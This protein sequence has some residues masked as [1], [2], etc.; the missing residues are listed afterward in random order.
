MDLEI[1]DNYIKRNENNSMIVNLIIPNGVIGIKDSAFF[2][3]YSLR[4][5]SMPES[6][7]FIE[8][9]AFNYCFKITDSTITN[10]VI[11]SEIV[12]KKSIQNPA[13]DWAVDALRMPLLQ[14]EARR[15]VNS[16]VKDSKYNISNNID[17]LRKIYEEAVFFNKDDVGKKECLK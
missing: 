1:K 7:K 16:F 9:D 8:S 11:L 14:P 13:D 3:C 5:V 17:Y 2:K 6:L 15:N 12:Q 4:S 10:G